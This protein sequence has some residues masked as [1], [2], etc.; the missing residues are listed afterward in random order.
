MHVRLKAW[1]F[2]ATWA[3][4]KAT[5]QLADPRDR[6]ALLRRQGATIGEDCRILPR[7]LGTEPHRVTIGD[8]CYI[9]GGAVFLTH[10]AATWGCAEV[11]TVFDDIVLGDNVFIGQNAILLP[12]TRVGDNV[13]VGAGCVVRGELPADMVY[14]GNP[15][16]P[17]CTVAEY[18]DKA[19]GRRLAQGL[20]P[21]R[22]GKLGAP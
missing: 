4:R 6:P 22:W 13:I 19:R 7:S 17:V 5:V 9:S 18:R 12:G 11:V 3:W 20:N 10:D 8:H 14:A 21:D 2:R 16:R 15:A 1:K